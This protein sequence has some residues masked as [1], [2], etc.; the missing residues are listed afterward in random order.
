MKYFF[1]A[2]I[3]LSISGL[4]LAQ[5]D[6][7]ANRAAYNKI[8]QYLKSVPMAHF[9]EITELGSLGTGLWEPV[10]VRIHQEQD[11]CDECERRDPRNV[12]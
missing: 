12:P 10:R 1:I 11:R 8:S 4:K 9:V 5:E 3:L 6:V 2:A 7:K